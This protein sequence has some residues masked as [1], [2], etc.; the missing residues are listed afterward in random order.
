MF[1]PELKIGAVKVVL[2]GWYLPPIALWALYP[3][4]RM[5]NNKARAFVDYVQ[6]AMYP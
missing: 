6:E 2:G 1:A 3:A 4:G 5:V